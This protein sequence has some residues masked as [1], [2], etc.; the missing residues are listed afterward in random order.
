MQ[1]DY[2]PA[3]A[4]YCAAALVP[5]SAH[6]ISPSIRWSRGPKE[7]RSYVLTMTDLDVPKDLSLMNKPGTTI[8]PDAPRVPFIHWVLIDIPPTIRQ[9]PRGA[10]SDGF[11]A[12]GRPVGR[13]RYGVTGSNVYSFFYPPGSPLAGTRGGYDG[14]CPP[15]N[16]TIPH[17]YVTRIF[18]LDI[19]TLGLEG[20]FSGESA[21]ERMQG[22]V[23]ATGSAQALS[24]GIAQ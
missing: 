24:A 18:A 11:I 3:S 7:T 20:V 1:G 22:H 14:P 6:N 12:G 15:R 19:P 17:R 21:L 10:G 9:L 5:A 2:L 4:V 23:L 13:T 16:D 8:S